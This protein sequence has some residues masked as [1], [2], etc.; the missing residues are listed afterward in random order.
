MSST[1][2]ATSQPVTPHGVCAVASARSPFVALRPLSQ[3]A[4]L[5]PDSF[6]GSRQTTN[7]SVALDHGYQM[8]ENAGNLDNFRIA[9]GQKS[10]ECR[11]PVYMDSD[12]YKWLEAAAFELGRAPS[13]SLRANVDEA[14]SLIQ[15]AQRQDGYLNTHYQLAEPGNRWVNFAHGHEL[16]CAGHLFQAAV[17]HH[18]ATG[19]TRLIE[20]SRRFAD[21]ICDSFGEGKR[22]VTPGHPEI[23]MA[24]VELYR[25][26][27][28]TRYLTQ[29]KLFI[30]RRGKGLLGSTMY[31]AP[32]YYQDR[33]PVRELTAPEG[34]AVRLMY[35]MAGVTDLL[36]EEQHPRLET[37]ME[38]VWQDFVSTKMYVTGGAGSRFHLEA[39]GQPY[40]LTNELAYTETC[41]AIGSIMWSWRRLLQTGE[42]RFADLIERTL[43][44]AVLPGVSLDGRAYF[45]TNLLLSRGLPENLSRGWHRRQPWHSCA[46]CPP[47]VM[48][49]IASL[50]HYLATEDAAGIQ[51]HQYASGTVFGDSGL[52]LDVETRYPWDG[53]V[54]VRVM[55]A[56]SGARAVELRVPAWC[57]A[58][59]LAVN[60]VQ[61]EIAG[62]RP[63]YAR[64]ERT[65]RVGDEI[66]L[67]LPMRPRLVEA[68]PWVEP[69]R[70]SVAIE[71]GPLVYCIESGDQAGA[72]LFDLRIDPRGPLS[73]EWSDEV[74]GGSVVVRGT[75]VDADSS[76]WGVAL[77]RSFDPGRASRA[78]STPITA[79]PY[80]GWANRDVGAMRIWIPRV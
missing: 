59:S 18:R 12:L 7:R 50:G 52:R 4:E 75:G 60:G 29:A 20:V 37:A 74:L 48:R 71:R 38:A 65:W 70:E 66:T 57:E 16:Y 27:G 10:G 44:N 40:E 33:V 63:G 80:F 30:N 55:A 67:T 77:Y 78:V 76:D 47:N 2:S 3:A 43:Y 8:L 56:S 45:Y 24:L 22:E 14:V 28:E 1:T 69:N 42:A 35:L 25:E 49:L 73:D 13:D 21:H 53:L 79:I 36:M 15:R 68:H 9:G 11:G 51:I 62:P 5:A 34:H 6:W 19:D 46:C 61:G 72:S 39:F 64:V 54:R 26:T 41:A 31:I 58:A 32:A 23:E 17:A